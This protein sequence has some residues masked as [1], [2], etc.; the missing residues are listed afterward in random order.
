MPNKKRG[1]PPKRKSE[2]QTTPVSNF[3]LPDETTAEIASLMEKL[4]IPS[5]TKVI[6]LAI[7]RMARAELGTLPGDRAKAKVRK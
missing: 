3:R 6:V 5:R 4:D 2:R 1:R 7:R